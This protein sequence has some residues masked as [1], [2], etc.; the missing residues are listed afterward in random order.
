MK[1]V[2]SIFLLIL[3]LF[4]FP[5]CQQDQGVNEAVS[6]L[7]QEILQ[8]IEA[9]QIPSLAACVIKND[10]IVWENYYGMSNRENST[11][12]AA[13]TQYTI[14]SISKTVL[15]TAAMQLVEKGQLDLEADINQYLPFTLRN[16]GFP[17]RA[18]TVKMLMTHTSGLAHPA[19]PT[20]VPGI[21]DYY[22]LD[23]TPLIKEWLKEYIL[24]G[25]ANYVTAVWKDFAP[26]EAELYS[27]IG[28]SL[29][30][31]IVEL[32]SGMEYTEYCRNKIFLPLGMVNTSFWFTD[33]DLAKV[34]LPYDNNYVPFYHYSFLVYPVG[35]IK[36]S[37]SEFSRF[38]TA[39]MNGGIYNGVRIL[40]Q[41]TVNQ[42]LT[43]QNQ[44]SGTCLI[45]KYG[46]GNWYMH[47]GGERGFATHSAFQKDDKLA[48]IIFTNKY[49]ES[50]YPVG[51][52]YELIRN[53]A[54]KY[55]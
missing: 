49:N 10:R 34:A 17:D 37:I 23:T 29:L 19:T 9:E 20:E 51:K 33:L 28:T 13:D 7:D 31:Y 47:S 5:H 4:L 15:I 27:N 25:G 38:I 21:Y 36:T 44:A 35:A 22:P 42:I 54:Y 55:R 11:P 26:G 6:G 32:V 2:Y 41:D 14:M 45:W 3:L 1:K 48:F 40:S 50:V 39:Y 18:I 53:Q 52:L 46:V 30:A 24:P 12:A 8:A 16:P 43:I